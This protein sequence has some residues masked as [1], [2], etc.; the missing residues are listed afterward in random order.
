MIVHV[1]TPLRSYTGEVSQ[2]EATGTTVDELLRDLDRKYPGVR[3]RVVDEHGQLRPHIKLF[4]DQQVV[5][6]LGTPL[7]GADVLHVIAA[8]SGG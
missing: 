8:L 2:V 1:P 4:L 7:A 6:D 3:F 5:E